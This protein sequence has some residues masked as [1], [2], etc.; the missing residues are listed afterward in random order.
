MFKI[1]SCIFVVCTAMNLFTAKPEFGSL[2]GNGS[3]HLQ[4]CVGCLLG[5]VCGDILGAIPEGQHMNQIQ[6]RTLGKGSK[7]RDFMTGT[8]LGIWQEGDR[9]GMYTDDSSSVLALARSLI[10]CNGLDPTDVSKSYAEWWLLAPFRGYPETAESVLM[11]V[12]EGIDP[13]ITGRIAFPNGSFAN[14]AAMRIAPVGL[15]FRHTTDAQMRR[16]VAHAVFSSHIHPE[17]VDSAA[18]LARAISFAATHSPTKDSQSDNDGFLPLF[19]PFEFLD[20]LE[21][22]AVTGNMRARLR[23]LREHFGSVGW[24]DVVWSMDDDDDGHVDRAAVGPRDWFQIRG[25]SAVGCALWAFLSHWA[26]TPE[27]AIISAV[28]LGGDADTVGSMAGAVAGALHGIDAF[29]DSVRAPPPHPQQQR[30]Q[31]QSDLAANKG[32]AEACP[33]GWLPERWWRDMETGP[34]GREFIVRTARELAALDLREPAESA[35]GAEA[36]LLALGNAASGGSDGDS[37]EAEA[38]ARQAHADARRAYARIAA[39]QSLKLYRLRHRAEA[40]IDVAFRQRA[41]AASAPDMDSVAQSYSS[42]HESKT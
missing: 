12:R 16:A 26:E 35:P 23:R 18:V 13:S 25:V 3:I 41:S 33:C 20:A 22:I 11:S 21:A 9:K 17:A 24:A 40:I 6:I 7:L 36:A 39:Q 8:H 31:Q 37:A 27:E 30:Q 14:G 34:Y 10:R 1:T 29:S 38:A 19:A 4:R 28:D 42:S 2:S 32:G 15:A 5:A